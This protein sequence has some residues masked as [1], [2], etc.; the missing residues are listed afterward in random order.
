MK[1]PFELQMRWR[2]KANEPIAWR[3]EHLMTGLQSIAAPWGIRPNDVPPSPDIPE[4]ELV[5][6]CELGSRMCLDSVYMRIAYTFRGDNY[7]QDT[8]E[9]DD[10]LAS[11]VGLSAE[12]YSSFVRDALPQY[13]RELKPYRARIQRNEL[14][15]DDWEQVTNSRMYIGRDVDGRSSVTRIWA[16]NYYDRELCHRA[17]NLSPDEILARLQEVVETVYRINDGIFIVYSSK[18]LDRNQTEGIGLR[19]MPL[20]REI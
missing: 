3:H 12:L 19:L 9:F 16:A 20:L 7:L 15:L 10:Y 1:S 5:V 4:G 2:T 13:I 8:G 18:I 17:F 6:E 11:D 14:A